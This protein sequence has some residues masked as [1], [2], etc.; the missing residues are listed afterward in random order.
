MQRLLTLTATN[1]KLFS[2]CIS[3]DLEVKKD[4]GQIYAIGA[5]RGDRDYSFARSVKNIERDLEALDKY[6]DGASFI[7]GHNVIDHDLIHIRVVNPNLR[8]LSL[9]VIDT[10]RL[11]PLAF[12]RNHYHHLIKHY[13]DGGIIREQANNPELD[14]H[15]ALDVFHDEREALA[16]KDEDLLIAWHWLCIS[17][18]T[19]IDQALDHLFFEIR[20]ADKPTS[21]VAKA[22]IERR[23]T[24][25]T[26]Q[27]TAR[28][29]L[30]DIK[31]SDWVLAYVLAWLSVAGGNSVMP[32]WVRHQ[33][34][35]AGHLV[36]NLRDR[37]C[38]SADCIWC[39]E[40]H[41][42]RK[43]LKRWFGFDDFRPIPA[44]ENGRS[45]QQAIVEK[46]M[47]DQSV[48][49]ILPTGS[50][51][52]LCYQI[53]A[54][55]RYNKTGA[56]TV[57]ISPL[58]AL[59]KDQVDGL[60]EKNI[61][62]CVTVNGLLSMLE[63]N[64]ALDRIRRGNIGI[65]LIS[66]EQLRSRTLRRA[67]EQRE[68]GTWVLDEA[69][70]LSRWGHDFR[71]D[72]L[73]VG[74]F[75]QE[76]S[77]DGHRP[78]VLCLTATAKP[79]VVNDIT[80]HFK[81][82]LNIQLEVLDGGTERTNLVF[83]VVQTTQPEKFSHIY[84]VLTSKLHKDEP[85]GA[86]VYCATRKRSEEVA[87]YLQMKGIAADRFHAG[88][89]PET[90]KVVQRNFIDGELRAIAAT[91]AFGMGIDKPDV[92]L[93]IHA[94][95]PGSLENYIQE[96]GRAGR[97]Q[98]SALC[99]LL[100]AK[101]DVERQF[102]MSARS[103]ISRGEINGILRALKNLNRK[104]R[105]KGEVV[106]T[107]GE[108]LDEDEHNSSVRDSATSDT[109]VR[110]AVAWLEQSEFLTREENFVNVFPS[111]L[112]V[113]SLAE[114]RQKLSKAQIPDSY[115]KQLLSIAEALLQADADQAIS[116]DVLMGISGL[117]PE[118]LRRA[119]Y[120]LE[121]YGIANNDTE[122]TVFV[123]NAVKHSSE[124]RLTEACK[125]E[126]AFIALMREKAPNQGKGDSS[127][128]HLR[129]AA[130]NL[131]NQGEP[132]PLPERLWRIIRGISYDGREEDDGAAG[133]ITVR[134]LDSETVH[135]TLQR[136]WK[137]LEETAEIRREAAG[138]LL[139]HLLSRLPE[140]SRGTDL[141]SATTLRKLLQAIE[142]DVMLKARVRYPEKLL[143][144]ALLWLHDMEVLRLN[145][146]LVVF[147]PAM[148]IRL[149]RVNR[150]TFTKADFQPLSLHY[151][152]QVLQIHVMEE[153]AERGLQK[154]SEALRLAMDY[155]SMNENVFLERWLPGRDKEI[156]RQTSPDSWQSIVGNLNN[157]VQQNIVSD[158]REHVNALIL[159]GPGSG[160]TRVLVHRIAYLIRVRRENA[161][162]IIALAYNRHAAVDIRRRLVELIGD[163]SF[164][165][166]VLTCHALA[167][168]LAGFSFREESERPND[169]MFK[170]VMRTAVEV[171]RGE[172]LLPE[173]A[174]ERRQRLLSGFQWILVDEYQDIGSEQY[175]LICALAGRS[176]EE[177]MGKLSLFAVGDDDQNIYSFRGASVEYIRRFEQD[178]KAQPSWLTDNYRSTR[179]II[180]SANAV[181]E[182]ARERMKHEHPIRVNRAR[183]KI[184]A[185]GEWEMLDPV[186]LGRVQILPA[187]SDEI[188]QA[189][190][191]ITEFLRLQ[192]LAQDWS[193]S[194]CAVIVREWIFLAPVR[195]LCESRNIP[196]QMVHEEIPRFLRLRESR[197]LLKWLREREPG[198]VD[199]KV[200]NKWLESCPS[201]DWYDLIRQA[202]TEYLEETGGSETT[203]E[204]FIE[205]LAE[206]GQEIRRRQRGL[207]LL[208][209]H[210]AKGLEFDHVAVMDGGWDHT[211]CNEDPDAERR[212]YYVAM[213]RARQT[214]MLSKIHN[215][216]GFHNELR[217]HKAVIHRET[218]KLPLHSKE[219]EHQF[220][221]LNLQNIDIGYAGRY[222]YRN[223]I[224][225]AISRL[226]TGDPIK[227][228]IEE[229]GTWLLL[230]SSGRPVGK[231]AKSFK[232]PSGMRC[233]AAEVFAVVSWSRK[234]SD[235]KFHPSLKCDEWEVVVPTLV[236]EPDR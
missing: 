232:P 219:V 208:T 135:V 228:K 38:T 179:N 37:A 89:P 229:N 107:A 57:V 202:I 25:T 53:P 220:V 47:A 102:G 192:E 137:A 225:K 19:G 6:A 99:I 117:S 206:W 52:S 87:R 231:L 29:L 119:L 133:S 74:R 90:K 221:Q 186:S 45:M 85:G 86:I 79:D 32:P 93:V 211:S 236:F 12:P 205:W 181:I 170:N 214:L 35:K 187:G 91:N 63:R 95:I 163:D 50:G 39:R 7:L 83:E 234:I 198:I 194:R 138:V 154:M 230:C 216:Q 125:L 70:C 203:V 160:K 21:Q 127:Q 164:G 22:A 75:I 168:R 111:S 171:L 124:K 97:D 3:L 103:R 212:L 152:R 101:D 17:E 209:A 77:S 139:N 72:Y 142:S 26:C 188:T 100:Y 190:A 227:V 2:S 144:R 189:Q 16:K 149:Q 49:G 10:L 210:R 174:D 76:K 162:S 28:K 204:S 178:Y 169:E 148:M 195:A 94:D 193:W 130:Q 145:K 147:R 222:H 200:L 65:V 73:Y 62:C 177:D 11:S 140:R 66:P 108:I 118:N 129:F 167:M 88:L 36:R 82:K 191:V 223:P 31:P 54:I 4:N 8:L 132:E 24:N 27:M 233:R 15:L 156:R 166:T 126:K 150:K 123:H 71:P 9:P 218:V 185:G 120:T 30:A 43:E 159:A 58:V 14:A 78:P 13:K 115:R 196:V 158:D 128:L 141:L 114:A 41:D 56:L 105:F 235:N 42:A 224:H 20:N 112:Q 69:H 59:M 60:E 175:E 215:S 165:V 23:L 44:N 106:A 155:F 146:G 153:F 197:T 183:E 5:V 113:K 151:E 92:R 180:E 110:S 116:T 68:I 134:R 184:P 34:P 173:E 46:V 40:Q 199:G 80:Q 182:K 109:R 201:N 161:R 143:D 121:R 18:P 136:E 67:L 51:K 157:S 1:S 84:Q 176:Q 104:N 61:C 96:A 64:D 98:E 122:I 48:L 213:T 131:R 81:E 55:S 207:L 217:G 226:S 33:F 172:G